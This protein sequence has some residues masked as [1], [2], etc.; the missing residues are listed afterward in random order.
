VLDQASGRVLAR[1]VTGALPHFA[2]PVLSGDR[3][4]IGTLAGVTAF[5]GA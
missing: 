2:S 3:L 4:L 5:T 1:L